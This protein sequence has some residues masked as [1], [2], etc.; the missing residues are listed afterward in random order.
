MFHFVLRN[1]D[2]LQQTSSP[3]LLVYPH[4]G[5]P[6]AGFAGAD[7]LSIVAAREVVIRGGREGAEDAERRQD[8]G[9]AQAPSPQSFIS[10]SIHFQL[11]NQ[12]CSVFNKRM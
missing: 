5:E 4:G 7:A 3:W 9:A 1:P 2:S 12:R 11:V 8:G 10:N 6:R